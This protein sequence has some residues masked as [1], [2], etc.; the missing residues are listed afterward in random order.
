MKSFKIDYSKRMI[1]LEDGSL[2][3]LHSADGF[4][5]IKKIWEYTNWA[6]KYSYNFTWFGRPIIQLPDDL[7]RIQEIICNVK[8][9]LIIETGIAHGGSLIFYASLLKILGGGRVIG[10]DVEIRKHNRNAI[11][12]HILSSM[13]NLIEGDSTD[14]NIVDSVKKQINENDVVLVI[15]DSC[16]SKDHVLKELMAYSAFV[17]Q[18]SY[19]I[20]ADGIMQDVVGAHRTQDDWVYNNPQQA[21]DEF[22]KIN[23]NFI[24]EDWL[25]VFK[26]SEIYSIPSY[27]QNGFL[28]RV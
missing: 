4:E 6:N 18:N 20:V 8:P 3:S 17:T 5:I 1:C 22:I 16:H 2:V 14:V 10:I 15:L 23:K 7:M 28:K 21:I 27:Y 11:E 12:S 19:I 9:T 24:K 25:P 13:I 26:E